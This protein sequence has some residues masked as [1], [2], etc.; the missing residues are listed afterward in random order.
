MG[1]KTKKDVHNVHEQVQEVED[2][3]EEVQHEENL[4]EGRNQSNFQ[5][6]LNMAADVIEGNSAPQ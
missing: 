4:N 6:K 2:E 1:N 3:Y 5:R